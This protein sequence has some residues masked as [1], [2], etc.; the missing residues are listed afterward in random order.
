MNYFGSFIVAI[1]ISKLL[2]AYFNNFQ[3]WEN[4]AFAAN[5]ARSIKNENL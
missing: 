5:S 3:Y 4:K 1:Y 2:Q